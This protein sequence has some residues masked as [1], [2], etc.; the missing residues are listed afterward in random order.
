MRYGKL[1][2]FFLTACGA[3]IQP[4]SEVGEIFK[5]QASSLDG[6]TEGICAAL[7][8][9]EEAPTTR[10]L[11][12]ETGGCKLPGRAAVNY[13]KADQFYFADLPS[14]DAQSTDTVHKAVRGQVWLNK[15]LL[16]LASMISKTMGQRQDAKPGEIKL[17]DSAVKQ[18]Q[19]L[20]TPKLTLLEPPTIDIAR[21]TFSMLINIHIEGALTAD[22]DI[23]IDGKVIDNAIAVTVATTKDQPFEASLLKNF[24][25][26]VLVVPHAGDVYLDAFIDINVNRIGLDAVVEKQISTFFNS[27]VKSMVDGLMVIEK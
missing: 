22:H 2:I 12:I 11:H 18:L 21:L 14:A 25:T 23:K 10:G 3:P 24:Q 6:K 9:R 17:P 1:I 13:A 15:N 26:L 16:D 8:A 20:V 19:G 5:G 7:A 4:A 27:G